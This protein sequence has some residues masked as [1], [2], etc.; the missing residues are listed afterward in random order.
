MG[1]IIPMG[2]IRGYIEECCDAIAKGED[3]DE[4]IGRAVNR[5]AQAA[6]LALGEH[7]Q[8]VIKSMQQSLAGELETIR[9]QMKKLG[10]L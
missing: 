9:D 5:V 3:P 10:T 8:D 6:G 4:M 1:A 7:I 2:T